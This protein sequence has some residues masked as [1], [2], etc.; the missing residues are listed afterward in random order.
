MPS[1]AAALA[2]SY[3]LGS[4]PTAYLFVKWLKRVDVR[5]VGSGNVG[6]TNVTRIAGLK[7]GAVVFAVDVLKGLLAVWVVSPVSRGELTT[8]WQLGCGVAAVLGHMFPV[9]LRF[10]GGKGVATA[11][12]VLLGSMPFIALLCLAM[13]ASCFFIWRYVSVASL[14]VVVALP[15]IQLIARQ[16][17]SAVLLG[18]LLALLITARHRSNIQRLVQGTEHR[19][20]ASR[21]S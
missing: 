17:A 5:T 21:P 12:G 20:G 10:R 16:P 14:A 3:L 19:A 7:V 1:R 18:A 4:V 13:W 11:I 9:W 6:A 8:T 15:I 2:V